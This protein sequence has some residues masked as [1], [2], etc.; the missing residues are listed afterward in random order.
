MAD[1][2][3]VESDQFVVD[4][5]EAARQDDVAFLVVGDPFGS[6]EIQANVPSSWLHPLTGLQSHHTLVPSSSCS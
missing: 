6:V 4:A 1:R 3:L 2:D 5:I